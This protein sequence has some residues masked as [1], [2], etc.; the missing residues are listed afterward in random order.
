MTRAFVLISSTSAARGAH[1]IAVASCIGELLWLLATAE[2]AAVFVD[3]EPGEGV[4]LVDV[5]RELERRWPGVPRLV[6]ARTARGQAI[7]LL[8]ADGAVVVAPRE[9]G[10]LAHSDDAM[11]TDTPPF[12]ADN[13]G[14]R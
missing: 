6:L 7:G 11:T 13:P 2:A 4:S 14:P 10:R 3:A 9:Q 8:A 1:D 12:V 5:L